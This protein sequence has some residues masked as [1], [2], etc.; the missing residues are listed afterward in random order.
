VLA[1]VFLGEILAGHHRLGS[2]GVF[3]TLA[4]E[5]AVGAVAARRSGSAGCTLIAAAF[6][7]ISLLAF[8]SWAFHPHGFTTFRWILLLESLALGAGAIRL[9][10]AYRRHGVQLV[11]VAGLLTMFLALT[12]VG[13]A[14]GEALDPRARRR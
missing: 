14:V 8:I 4:V 12:F 3:W 6:A 13:E 10:G 2:G 11:N 5:A 7:S 1:L 9:R